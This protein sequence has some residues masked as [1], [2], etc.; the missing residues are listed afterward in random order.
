MPANTITGGPGGTVVIPIPPPSTD[1]PDPPIRQITII[2]T[3]PLITELR[4]TRRKTNTSTYSQ[5]TVNRDSI[6]TVEGV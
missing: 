5:L 6:V 1:V 2:I 3:D 4:I